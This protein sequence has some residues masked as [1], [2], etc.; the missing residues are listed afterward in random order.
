MKYLLISICL[1]SIILF[2]ECRKSDYL[3][4]N[5]LLV[6]DQGGGTGTVT[7]SKE[8]EI[9]LDGFVFV[10]DGQTLTIEPGTVVRAKAGKGTLASALI[11]SRGGKL[12]ARGTSGNPIVF[13]SEYDD[14]KGSVPL[15]TAG[16]W[17]GVII[18]G[19]A[20]INSPSG[21]GFIEGIPIS[22][23][24]GI[25]GGND[26]DDNSGILSYVSILHSGTEIGEDNE[27]NGL[28]LGGIGRKT[29]IDNIE[30]IASEDD[31]F[32][33][34]GGTVNCTNLASVFCHD[35]AFDFDEG[36]IGKLQFLLAVMDSSTGDHA[37]E[38]TGTGVDGGSSGF[39][40][41]SIYNATFIGGGLENSSYLI[42][43][44]RKSIGFYRNSIFQNNG[45]GIAI[46]YKNYE[47]SFKELKDGA[48][49]I[50]NNLF[51]NVAQ[52]IQDSIFSIY[53]GQQIPAQET[54]YIRGYFL[55]AK[56]K[57]E[58]PGLEAGSFPINLLPSVTLFGEM[59]PYNASWYE[60]VSYKGAFGSNNWLAG[61]SRLWKENIIE[62]ALP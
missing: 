60:K 38:H 45:R 51:Y 56:N 6:S 37:A 16:L 50:E 4:S 5:Q 18:L 23:P 41:P 11:V 30:V 59:A 61:W 12:I 13:T 1:I 57:M 34:F 2:Q 32:E 28:T 42:S 3:I 52:N 27:I 55:W 19:N 36:Y 54:E 46:E 20:P 10:N 9:L 62:G 21:E 14:L 39:T 17:G 43:F 47:S 31:G 25:Y 48:L 22:E 8:S 7:W 40:A 53:P 29:I 49:A 24:R 33:F 26:I 15:K 44:N 58:N 35:D